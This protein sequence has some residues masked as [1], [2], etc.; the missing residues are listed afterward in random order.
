MQEEDKKNARRRQ[1][2]SNLGFFYHI[3]SND[4]FFVDRKSEICKI[5]LN[6][7][8]LFKNKTKLKY[9]HQDPTQ[10]RH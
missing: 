5:E 1:Q 9:N 4:M 10:I 8:T 2:G 3:S 7:V 6:M